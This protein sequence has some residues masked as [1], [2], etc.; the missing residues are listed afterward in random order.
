MELLSN[1]CSTRVILVLSNEHLVG[2]HVRYFL[3]FELDV[4]V[5]RPLVDNFD[6]R[7][8]VA[9]DLIFNC[10]LVTV[11]RLISDVAVNKRIFREYLAHE[12]LFAESERIDVSLSNVDKLGLRVVT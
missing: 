9:H 8:L 11:A 10:A 5:S 7:V 1:V 6:V 4:V 12:E 3:L 2:L